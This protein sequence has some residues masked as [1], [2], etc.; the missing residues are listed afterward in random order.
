MNISSYKTDLNVR[1]CI[2]TINLPHMSC[3][4]VFGSVFINLFTCDNKIVQK[5]LQMGS[6][7]KI[8]MCV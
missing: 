5:N 2:W 3:V 6:D 7:G 4:Y 8:A 1:M